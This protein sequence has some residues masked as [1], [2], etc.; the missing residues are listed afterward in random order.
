[1][2]SIEGQLDVL[3]RGTR[4]L[5]VGLAG[6]GREDIEVAALDRGDEFAANEIVIARLVV[7]TSTRYYPRFI[8]AMSRSSGFGSTPSY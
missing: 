6:D 3:G 8:L 1:M 2:G 4:C 7:R 5:G